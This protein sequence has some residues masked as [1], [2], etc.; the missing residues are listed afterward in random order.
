[1]SRCIPEINFA[2]YLVD[3]T[4]LE[5]R[6]TIQAIYDAVSS[7]GFFLLTNTPVTQNQQT[8]LLNS[9]KQFFDLP[10]EKKVAL[11]V[12]NGGVA[13]RGYM[14]LGGEYTHGRQDW[15]EGFY[16]GPEH[17]DDHALTGMPLHGRN[18]FPDADLPSMRNDV[19]KY[20]EQ[21]SELGKMLTE[22]LSLGLKLEKNEL[23][24]AWL[25]PEP[26]LLFRCFKYSPLLEATESQS[27]KESFGIGEHTDFGYLTILKVD[28]P[29][30]QIL[31]PSDEWVDVPV[32]ENA[33]IVNVGDML[34]QLTHGRFRSR[35]HRVQRPKSV[36]PP[37]YSFP[38]FFDFAWNTKMQRLSLDHLPPLTAEEQELARKRWANTSFRKVEG[39]WAQ[40]LAKKVQKVFPDLNLPDF[41]PNK[42]PSTRFTR[43]VKA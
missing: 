43:V 41:E 3:A 14:P 13:W 25:E 18:Q 33:F 22:V 24:R 38:L 4:S 19:L 10:M 11:D 32:I 34:D 40:Y 8:A 29:G 39:T 15:K 35:P 1:M 2:P 36:S 17:E 16:V 30:L 28:S 21:V 9:A 37:R 5:G 26:I 31:S 20:L 23:R 27:L 6:E 12:A 42:A 7:W